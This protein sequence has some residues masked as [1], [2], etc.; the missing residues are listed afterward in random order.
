[1]M[2]QSHDPEKILIE[3]YSQLMHD[4]NRH[5]V[6]VWQSIC[7]LIAAITAFALIKDNLFS[8]DMAASVALI[9]CIWLLVHVYDS[10]FWYNRNT[11]IIAN[12]EKQFLRQDDSGAMKSFFSENQPK[13]VYISHCIQRALGMSVAILVLG[14]QF[15]ETILPILL[16]RTDFEAFNSA[17]WF[18][19]ACGILIWV[20]KAHSNVKKYD[21]FIKSS[22]D[23]SGNLDSS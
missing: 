15:Y 19:A 6:I 22:S 23:I 20:I 13:G 10:S 18:I 3:M 21:D 5:I 11:A 1:M 4:V 2:V 16:A 8:L 14:F 12:I 7:M 17:P 9:A